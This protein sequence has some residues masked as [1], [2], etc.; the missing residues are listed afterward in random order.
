MALVMQT[1]AALGAQ[2]GA[3]A[4]S[5]FAGPRIRLAFSALPFLGAGL[6]A[7]RLLTG[8]GGL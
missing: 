3:N 7:Y 1:G 4:T 8:I 5:Y 2:V 6:M